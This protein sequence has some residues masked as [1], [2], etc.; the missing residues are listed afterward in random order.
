MSSVFERSIG[1][2]MTFL[3]AQHSPYMRCLSSRLLLHLGAVAVP[4]SARFVAKVVHPNAAGLATL[5]TMH[6]CD[7]CDA[8]LR[9]LRLGLLLLLL[10]QRMGLAQAWTFCSE[11]DC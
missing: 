7:H 11:A 4:R 8:M 9:R 6:A 3:S 5:R 1:I 10:L 2:M